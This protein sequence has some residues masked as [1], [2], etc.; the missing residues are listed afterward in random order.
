M[1]LILAPYGSVSCQLLWQQYLSNPVHDHDLLFLFWIL[2]VL[3][4][5]CANI[6]L[7][8]FWGLRGA[9]GGGSQVG[10]RNLY[11]ALSTSDSPNSEPK[12]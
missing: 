11:T 2:L 4:L 8:F 12:Y 9:R 7:Y 6:T 10:P 3:K 1:P 5:I